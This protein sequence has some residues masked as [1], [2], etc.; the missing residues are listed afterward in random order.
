MLLGAEFFAEAQQAF[1][2]EPGA[3]GNEQYIDGDAEDEKGTLDKRSAM[4][5][6]RPRCMPC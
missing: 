4:A 6:E 1:C 2:Q 5:G 3:E